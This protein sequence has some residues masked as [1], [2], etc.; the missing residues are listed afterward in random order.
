MTAALGSVAN[1]MCRVDFYRYRSVGRGI[2]LEQTEPELYDMPT[3]PRSVKVG[4]L[5]AEAIK[6]LMFDCTVDPQPETLC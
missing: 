3:T 5:K 2:H 1:C 6:T 4:M